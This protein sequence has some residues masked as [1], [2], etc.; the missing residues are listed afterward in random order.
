MTIEESLDLTPGAT[1]TVATI[2][3]VS[4]YD[5][6]FDTAVHGTWDAPFALKF[7]RGDYLV[8]FPWVSVAHFYKT[9]DPVA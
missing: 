8:T 3:A 9:K 4:Y 6:V 1:Y 7:R 5:C 2:A